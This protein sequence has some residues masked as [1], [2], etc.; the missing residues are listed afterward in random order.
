MSKKE[1]DSPSDENKDDNSSSLL[2]NASEEEE[3]EAQLLMP[4]DGEEELLLGAEDEIKDIENELLEEIEE[5]KSEVVSKEL[6]EGSKEVEFDEIAISESEKDLFKEVKR[7]EEDLEEE[8]I[9]EIIGGSSRTKI[10]YKARIAFDLNFNERGRVQDSYS[11]LRDLLE[12]FHY[13]VVEYNDMLIQT[14]LF[15]NDILILACPDA[16]KLNPYEITQIK[17]F[18]CNG[19]GLL[20]L[21]HAGG[22]HGRGTNL[23][24]L[25]REFGIHFENNQVLDEMY[26]YGL[27]TFPVISNFEDH[28]IIKNVKELC[29]RAGCSIKTSSPA[30]TIAFANEIADPTK[31]EVVAVSEAD[32][33]RVVAIGAYEMFRNEVVQWASH[34]KFILNVLEWLTYDKNLASIIQSFDAL[35][36]S[37]QK[38]QKQQS[39]KIEKTSK[40]GK[41][42]KGFQLPMLVPIS[43]TGGLGTDDL[44]II[45]DGFNDVLKV[46]QELKDEFSSLK[47]EFSKLKLEIKDDIAELKG[48]NTGLLRDF[49]KLNMDLEDKSDSDN[50]ISRLLMDLGK[51]ID[52]ILKNQKK[53]TK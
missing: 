31:A 15:K 45:I 42:G 4:V 53:A 41:Q 16:S 49:E 26:N 38:L 32:L 39:S 33:G 23:N 35:I 52:K 40:K 21:S 20:M 25:A 19:G 17:R 18:V 5:T 7:I 27:D 2:F 8:E 34:E 29:L 14:R 30:K 47:K 24:Q 3:E 1:Q 46:T 6:F 44:Q 13:Q 11:E 48:F 9:E 51:K 12:E 10:K 36:T 50:A 28:P 22:D 37:F 43:S